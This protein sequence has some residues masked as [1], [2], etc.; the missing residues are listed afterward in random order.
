[1]SLVSVLIPSFN[2]ARYLGEAVASVV[3]QT[4]EEIEL[5]VVDDASTDGTRDLVRSLEAAHRDR[6][7]RFK[8]IRYDHN[9]GVT[10]LLNQAIP[11][12][13]GEITCILDADDALERAF[14]AETVRTLRDAQ[15]K[16]SRTAFVYTDC[17]LVDAAG[18][19][20]GHG[21]ATPFDRA[22]LRTRSYISG[23]GP[24]LTQALRSVLPL[25]VR[26]RAG[27]KH[28]RWL[29]IVESGSEGVYVNRPL[30]RY[31]MHDRNLSGIGRRVLSHGTA[32]AYTLSNYW[33]VASAEGDA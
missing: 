24:T 21:H 17:V 9:G 33:P 5:V 7:T 4:Y 11:L 13:C 29:K 16:C 31:R 22:L 8:F 1:M 3:D 18:E 26:I 28:H 23:C 32:G 14:L 20:I 27:N 30:F 6:F 15:I 2:Y 25:D 19:I 12:L 10:N